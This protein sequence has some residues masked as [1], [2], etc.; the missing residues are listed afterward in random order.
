MDRPEASA[1]LSTLEPGAPVGRRRARRRA[2]RAAALAVARRRRRRGRRPPGARHRPRPDRHRADRRRARVGRELVPARARRPPAGGHRRRRRDRARRGRGAPAREPR[3]ARPRAATRGAGKLGLGRA[4]QRL[5]VVRRALPYGRARSRRRSAG[6]GGVARHRRARTPAG[7][8]GGVPHRGARRAVRHQLPPAPARCQP[9]DRALARGA[10]VLGRR[11]GGH[12]GLRAGRHRAQA[13][14]G[15]PARSRRARAGRAGRPAARRADG[16]RDGDRRRD[17]RA[18]PRQRFEV[19]P[20]GGRLLLRAGLGWPLEQ[21][22]QR[23]AE[24]GRASHAGYTLLAGE[25]VVVEDWEREG[26]SGSPRCWPPRACAAG[27][28]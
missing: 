2:A 22:G 9:A 20:G 21:I 25:P 11:A 7:G 27:R 1:L 3:A 18:R 15:P 14:G 5:D 19:C 6:L 16:A 8:A 23:E 17:A 13:R 10:G 12:R 28:A 26:A 4:A 24:I